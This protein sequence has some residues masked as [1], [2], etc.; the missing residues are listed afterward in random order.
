MN[1]DRDSPEKLIGIC[2]DENLERI[3]VIT[4]NVNIEF[5]DLDKVRQVFEKAPDVAIENF[6]LAMKTAMNDIMQDARMHHKYKSGFG[7]ELENRGLKAELTTNKNNEIAGVITLDE[8]AVPYARFVHE[9]T[10][11]HKI[12]PRNKKMLRWP[13]KD[14]HGFISPWKKGFVDHPGTKPDPFL[15][16]ATDRMKPHI[17][18]VFDFYAKRMAQSIQE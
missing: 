15:Y 6:T 12:F 10:R 9:G 11:P 8:E 5:K 7:A 14:G 16:Q 18:E 17:N 13:A 3:G 2:W 1:N 4:V